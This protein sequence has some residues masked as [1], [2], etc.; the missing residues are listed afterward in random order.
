MISLT[1]LS[2]NYEPSILILAPHASEYDRKLEMEVN[3]INA[4]LNSD[5]EAALK[6]Q[7]LASDEFNTLP[8][9]TKLMAAS[10]IAFR[11][12]ADFFKQASSLAQKYQT[13]RLS[14]HYR[15]LHVYKL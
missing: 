10:E 14:L 3:K 5:P 6:D 9:R 13:A 15:Q 4:K 11:R 8:E 12:K 2:Q 1:A 7:Y